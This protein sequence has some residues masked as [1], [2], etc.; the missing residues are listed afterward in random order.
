MPRTQAQ[1]EVIEASGA[2]AEPAVVEPTDLLH[3]PHRKRLSHAYVT[4]DAGARELSIYYGM[5]EITFDEERLFG[6]GE[7]L[8]GQSSFVA[9]TATTWGPGYEWAEIRSM[10]EALVGEGIVRRGAPVDAPRGGGLVASPLPPSVCPVP[11]TWSAQECES[12][13]RD[14]GGRPIEIGNLEAFL[15]VYRIAHPALDADGRQVG[16]ANVFPPGLRLDRA[17]EWRVCQYAG[18]RYRDDA[19]MN[20]TALKAMIKHWKPIMA[21]VLDVRAEVLS[22][23]ERSRNGWTVGDLHMFSGVLLTLPAYQL[24]K[25]GGS[26]PQPPLHPVLSSLFRISDGIRMATHLMLFLSEERTRSPEEPTTA[27]DLHEFT[28]RNGLFLAEYGVCAGPKALI[29]EFLATVFSGRPVDGEVELAPEVRNLLSHLP[30]ATDYALLGLQSWAVTRSVWLAM[31]LAYKALR[32][33]VDASGCDSPISE[34]LRGRLRRDWAGLDQA[35]IASDHERGVHGTVYTD[36]YEQA[37]RALRSPVGPPTL[38][39]R[40]ASG[41]ERLQHS[42]AAGELRRLLASKLAGTELAVERIAAILVDYLR[43]EQAILRAASELQ[44]AINALLDRP[45]PQRPFTARDVRV[46]QAMYGGSIARFPYLFDTL[47]QELGVRVECTADTIEVS[48]ASA[49]QSAENQWPACHPARPQ[50]PRPTGVM[51]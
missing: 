39:E 31:S 28:E 5:K 22:R 6:F 44:A 35:R 46:A 30:E 24:M 1:D 2:I 27:A 18:S 42:E 10:L 13:S 49:E 34:R 12:I 21:A 26:T 14:L 15:S 32:G 38:A 43:E 50:Q 11:R 7:Q 16:E 41:P 37:W 23:L 3:V 19:P 9:H 45:R 20:V 25:G 47:E 36:T 33:L 51:P 4:T 8:L 40:I 48:E 17:T 29:D